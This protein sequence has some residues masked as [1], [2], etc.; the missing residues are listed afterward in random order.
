MIT[1]PAGAAD[2]A[3]VQTARASALRVHSWLPIWTDTTPYGPAL[4]I[5]CAATAHGRVAPVARATTRLP[6]ATAL[7]ARVFSRPVINAAASPT[8]SERSRQL[9]APLV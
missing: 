2:S 3:S 1:W 7:V 4:A 9:M 8:A 5:A 6:F